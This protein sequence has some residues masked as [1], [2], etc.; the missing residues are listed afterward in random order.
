MTDEL[1]D[2]VKHQV[3]LKRT[4]FL[5]DYITAVRKFGIDEKWIEYFR[6]QDRDF[7]KKF[8]HSISIGA[9]EYIQHYNHATNKYEVVRGEE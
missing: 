1:S 2:K 6:E 8:A 7:I 5:E 4:M 9:E 3:M